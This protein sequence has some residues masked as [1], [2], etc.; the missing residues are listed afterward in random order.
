M[1]VAETIRS[2][3]IFSGLLREDIAK[4]LGRME[5]ITVSAGTTVFSQGDQGDAFYIIQSGTIQVVLGTAAGRSETIAV[6]GPQDWFGEMA[7]LSGEPR[8]ATIIAVKEATLWKLS[9]EAWDELIEKHPT[10]LLQFCATL[11]KRLSRAD[12]QYSAGRDAFNS[13]AEEFY[14]SRTP[15]QKQ[16]FRRVS[17]LNSIDIETADRLLQTEGARAFLAD[18]EKTQFPLMRHLEGGKYELHSFFRDFLREK[19]IA[20]EGKEIKQQLHGQIAAQYEGLG[21]W[22]QAIH[23]RINTQDWPE[24]TRLLITQ[25]DKL[26]NGA[27]ML[28]KMALE[29]IPQEHF[30]ADLRLVHMKANTLAHLGDLPGALRTYKEVLSTKAQ[31]AV[32]PEA[33]GRYVGMA[34]T[35]AQRK[36]Y[37]QAI[38]CLRTGLNLLEQEITTSAGDVTASYRDRKELQE[39]LPPGG[40]RVRSRLFNLLA[41]STRIFRGSSRGRWLGGIL[42]LAVWAYFWF[43]TPDIGLEREA[44]KELG[45]LCLTLIYWVFWVFPDYGVALIFALVLILTKLAPTETVLGGFASTTWFMTLGVLGLGAAIT[46]SGLFYR[47]SLQLV[48]VFPLTY[49]WQIVALG[50]MGVVVMALIPQQSARTAIISQMLQNLSDSLGYKNPS[51]ASTGMFVA[52]FLGLG[53]LGFLFLTGSTTSLI[54]WGLLPADVR[55]QFT[56]GYWF[57]AALPP[58]IV[59]IAIVLLG[60]VILYRPET[61]PQLSYKLVQ[62]QLDV[63]GPL[64]A[65]EWITQGVLVFMLGGWLTVSYHGIDG[66]WI[67]LIGLC[68]LINTGVLG[69]GMVKKGIDWELL[70]YMGATLGIPA[71][72]TRA[73][74]DEWLVGILSPLILP[75]VDHPAVS[76][77]IICLISYAFKLVFTSFLTVVAL[78]VALLPL[79]VDMGVSPWIIAMLVLVGSEVWFFRFQ[80]DWHT[81]A[82]STTESKGFSYRYMNWINPVYAVAYILA[83]I[84]A[85]PFWR[86]LGLMG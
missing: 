65:K 4:I 70:L 16:F 49:Y 23:Q 39:S 55:A 8:S 66:A 22:Q 38:N 37:A 84:A 67:A 78:T 58:T 33:I 54:A 26:L 61:K 85:I 56:W 71:L 64:S 52:S 68:V 81:L 62:N 18:L 77:I 63:L 73:K 9:R 79:S 48:R 69:W 7:L 11:S 83:L 60:T 14:S 2:I 51:K 17:L 13:L 42:G 25:Q 12:Q 80:V 31:G 50:I 29:N 72:L 41:P 44:T 57:L 45:V 28:V 27:A 32:A 5:E 21:D 15:E 46:S 74:I 34:D 19:L 82:F 10:W 35:L 53:Q 47:F 43:W 75:F 1:D 40:A 36:E 6:L 86:Y 20:E 24:I 59:V 3:P 76:F 30:F